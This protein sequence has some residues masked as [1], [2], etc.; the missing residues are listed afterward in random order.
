MAGIY[1][2]IP[3]CRKVCG[4]CDFFKNANLGQK[5]ALLAAIKKEIFIQ[6][7]YLNEAVETVYF[8]GGTPSVLTIQEVAGLLE[9]IN[10]HFHLATDTEITFEANP[11][12]LTTNYLKDLKQLGIN[13]LSIG[14]QSF[15]DEVL[16]FMNR[17]H[18]AQEAINCVKQAKAV[19][20]DNLSL[21]IIYGIP[22]TDSNYLQYNLQKICDLAPVHISA[23]H[24]TI[25][26]GTPFAHLKQKGKLHEIPDSD[27]ESQY[28][29]LVAF[30][31][32]KGYEQ[33]E[34]SNFC[35]DGQISR[36]NTNYWMQK[37]YLG[38]GPSAHSYNKKCRQWNIANI[39]TYI[40]AVETSKLPYEEEELSIKDKFNDYV[41]V[42]LRTKWGID[43][44][45]IEKVFGYSYV[46][47]IEKL[48][49]AN[50]NEFQRNASFITLKPEA[51]LRSDYLIA[52]FFVI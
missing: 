11:D 13:R 6:K 8:G 5:Q 33:Y 35:R 12:D 31:D 14:I 29:F 45:Y 48:V 40:S 20:F 30:L 23:Y 9:S 43:L 25:E 27:S 21:D 26:Q 42:R 47:N 36:H 2:H 32:K 51:F 49:A 24:L 34:I 41:M 10:D 17:R 44:S 1:L 19:G 38:L 7:N 4:Y 39:K 15:D 46:Q 50:P 3:F 37:P 16:R 52:K 22:D 28:T 18:T